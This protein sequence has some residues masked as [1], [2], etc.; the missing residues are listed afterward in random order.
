MEGTRMLFYECP[1]VIVTWDDTLKCAVMVFRG[2]IDGDELRNAL[3]SIVKLME[4]N[5]ARKL[6]TDARQMKAITQEDQR[7]VDVEWQE[8]ATAAGLAYDAVVLPKSA[9]AQMAINAVVKKIQPGTIEFA[10]F[11]STEEAAKWLRS[12]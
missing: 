1:G 10:Y 12:K 2:Y 9:V 11:S 5:R 3:L 4:A 7:W 8:K 6:L